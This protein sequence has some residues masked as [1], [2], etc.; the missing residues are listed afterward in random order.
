MLFPPPELGEDSDDN[1]IGKQN[2]KQGNGAG[3]KKKTGAWPR[4]ERINTNT[5]IRR[6]P[7]AEETHSLHRQES[8]LGYDSDGENNENRSRQATPFPFGKEGS[9]GLVKLSENLG[10]VHP[11]PVILEIIRT[12]VCTPGAVF[13]IE[14]IEDIPLYLP[15]SSDSEK[16]RH[17]MV[18][19][20]LGDGEVCIQALLRPEKFCVLDGGLVYEGCYVCLGN[21]DIVEVDVDPTGGVRRN[22][23][24]GQKMY[25]LVVGDMVTVGWNNVYLGMLRDQEV[26]GKTD[27]VEV[28]TVR[29]GKVTGPSTTPQPSPSKIRTTSAIPS[30]K[31]NTDDIEEYI[32]DNDLDDETFEKLDI[33]LDRVA[34]RRQAPASTK[35]QNKLNS[36]NPNSAVPSKGPALA[37]AITDP[38]QPLTLTPL[39]SIPNL[40]YKQNWMVNVLAVVVSL[41]PV[42]PAHLP[43]YTQ[44]TARLADPSTSK[45]VLLTVFLDPEEFSPEVG[46]AVLLVGVKN[47]RFDGGCLK[48]YA[49]DRPKDAGQGNGNGNG[50]CRWWMENPRGLEWCAGEVDYLLGWWKEQDRLQQQQQ[51]EQQQQQQQEDG[52]NQMQTC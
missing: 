10:S 50:M 18:R 52:E 49:S 38:S 27:Q 42:E 34:E 23:K 40:P 28:I 8:D 7:P 17:R 45:R 1:G 35:P 43:P 13:L 48:K 51:Q 36:N 5:G 11:K 9:P 15:D 33:S 31:L 12:R 6:F 2:Q 25:Y 14:K 46:S 30:A 22:K 19:L 16:A 37:L 21:F 3:E 26:V 29:D 4:I 32:S 41:S 47:H 20:V 39:R 44:R 24:Q